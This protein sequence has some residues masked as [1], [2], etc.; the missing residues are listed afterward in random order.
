MNQPSSMTAGRLFPQVRGF[1]GRLV[2]SKATKKKGEGQTGGRRRE[3][4]F[5][6]GTKKK[7]LSEVERKG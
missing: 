6:K 3:M 5:F 2:E 1:T 4:V 7:T